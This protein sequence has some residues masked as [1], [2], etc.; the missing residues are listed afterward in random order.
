MQSKNYSFMNLK[1]FREYKMDVA[2]FEHRRCHL[3]S[4]VSDNRG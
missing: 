2:M 1:I 4:K 3:E